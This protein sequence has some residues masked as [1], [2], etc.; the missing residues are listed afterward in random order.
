MGIWRG[1]GWQPGY[2]AKVVIGGN[3]NRARRFL[4]RKQSGKSGDVFAG[5]K[6]PSGEL[7][8]DPALSHKSLL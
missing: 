5:N 6:Q 3:S 4:A 1:E 8:H 7:F 2:K